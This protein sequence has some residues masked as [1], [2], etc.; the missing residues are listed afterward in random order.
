MIAFTTSDGTSGQLI[1]PLCGVKCNLPLSGVMQV[2]VSGMLGADLGMAPLAIAELEQ[3]G[4][5]AAFSA[6]IN[7]DPFFPLVLAA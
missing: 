5:D 7:S 2:N 3:R 1:H 4:Y 6:E